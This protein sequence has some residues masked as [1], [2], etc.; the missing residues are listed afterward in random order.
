MS[1]LRSDSMLESLKAKAIALDKRIR[2][3]AAKEKIKNEAAAHRRNVLAGEA[4]LH[5]AA[6]EGQTDFAAQLLRIIDDRAR[7]AAD[8]K[9]FGLAPIPKESGPPTADE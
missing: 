2:E 6:T 1:R 4:A 3:A 5:Y 8:R 7:S 9:L